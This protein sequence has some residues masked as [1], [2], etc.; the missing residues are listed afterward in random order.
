MIV[1]RV[2]FQTVV[3]ALSQI[4]ANKGRAFLTSLGIIIGI[5]AVITV[6][7]AL[8]G[9]RG[10]VLAQFDT[11]GVRMIFFDG[12]V[13]IEMETKV[14]WLDVQVQPDEIE[15]IEKHC[16]SVEVVTPV[17]RASCDVVNGDYIQRGVGVEGI[18]PTW[19]QI[20]SRQ[21]TYGRPFSKIDG[22][23]ARQVCLVNETAIQELNLD[24]DPTGDFIL[25]KDR[26]FQIVGVVETKAVSPMFG[27]GQ[28]RSEVYVPFEQGKKLNPRGWINHCFG[29]VVS[30]EKAADAQ[31]EVK[32]V[33]RKMRGLEP[34]EPDTYEVQVMQEFVDGFKSMASGITAVA[35][36]VVS[37]A[38]LVGGIG[39]M[40]IMLV[41][42][43]ERTRE[44]GLRK[45]VGARPGVILW[46]FLV[47]AA[48]LCLVGG[49]IG[50]VIAQTLSVLMS[51]GGPESPLGRAAVPV[52]A[53]ALA[54]GFSAGIGLVFGM[55]PA[56]KASRLDPIDALRHE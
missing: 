19:H 28:S 23:E 21:V 2:L 13:P 43:S 6:I 56:I 31:E 27:G 12:E 16:P 51:L 46:Q 45:A 35:G 3:L 50:V 48:T 24:K 29:S 8:G 34:D 11:V 42:V 9:M 38:L 18:W 40:N 22:E 10:W 33:L 26:R 20:W 30:A 41:S 52:W 5:A 15:A 49:A 54:C 44:I 32:F 36:G 17:W 4:W 53:I 1:A 25:I 7:A 47:E 55:F 39:I 14:S 37:I